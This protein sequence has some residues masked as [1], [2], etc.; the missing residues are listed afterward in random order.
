MK[1]IAL[2][3]KTFN[4]IKELKEKHKMKS[5]DNLIIDLIITKEKIPKD[6]FGSLKGKAKPF[7]RKERKEIMGEDERWQ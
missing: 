4:L 3:E 6:M 5:F 7:S 1:T 2:K